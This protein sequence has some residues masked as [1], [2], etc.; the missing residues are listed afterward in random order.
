MTALNLFHPADVRVSRALS[1]V[2]SGRYKLGSGGTDPTAAT[3][4]SR[5]GFC[6]CS[7]LVAWACGYPRKIMLGDD[8][9]TGA[10]WWN[11]DALLAE[12]RHGE[13]WTIVPAGSGYLAGDVVVYPSVDLDRDGKRDLI[14]HTGLVV[15]GGPLIATCRVVHCRPARNGKGPAVVR[16]TGDPFVGKATRRGTTRVNWGARV[17]RPHPIYVRQ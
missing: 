9:G 13:F 8:E 17:I 4:F 3:P 2:G 6:D 12:A 10:D 1:Q 16:T 15:E 5:A 11:T 14:G 7:G